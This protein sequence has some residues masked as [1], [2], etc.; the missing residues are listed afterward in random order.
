[1]SVAQWPGKR[2]WPLSAS[3]IREADAGQNARIISHAT[4]ARLPNTR[5]RGN[6]IAIQPIKPQFPSPDGQ[7]QKPQILVVSV[8]KFPH[9]GQRFMMF[10]PFIY[11][12]K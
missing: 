11:F 12:E 2:L 6:R 8:E 5:M 7:S 3:H 10:S 4:S 9:L 1:M